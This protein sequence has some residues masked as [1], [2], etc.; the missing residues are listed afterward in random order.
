MAVEIEIPGWGALSLKYLVMDYNGTLAVDGRLIDGVDIVL[1]RLAQ[2][3][4]LHVLTAD[5]FGLAKKGL[6]G[7]PCELSILARENQAEGKEKFVRQLG[8]D[9]T[10]AVGNGRND[11]LMLEA[12][13]LGIALILAEGASSETI[14]SADIVCNSIIDA[15]SLLENPLRLVAT[16]RS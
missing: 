16:L 13:A 10:V 9:K 14:A 15:L 5:T 12:S 8:A 7:I 3:L 2:K 1:A 6:S 4:D 11:R